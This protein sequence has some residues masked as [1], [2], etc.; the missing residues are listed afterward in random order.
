MLLAC[1]FLRF[2]LSVCCRY[3]SICRAC[4]L[5]RTSELRR[6]SASKIAFLKLDLEGSL[7]MLS[8]ASDGFSLLLLRRLLFVLLLLGD[9]SSSTSFL[10]RCST[11]SPAAPL[12]ALLLRRGTNGM[13]LCFVLCLEFSFLAA[14]FVRRSTSSS[15]CC[16][17]SHACLGEASR[18]RWALALP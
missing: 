15:S 18:F 9:Y 16:S 2:L 14:A 11:L 6:V 8:A 1:E 7:V 13:L 4:S 3:R 5:K 17:F 10:I 12:L